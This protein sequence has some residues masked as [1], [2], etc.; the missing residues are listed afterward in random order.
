MELAE[1]QKIDAI[2]YLPKGGNLTGGDQNGRVKTYTVEVSMTGADDSW[3]KVEITPSTQE[4]AN[5]TDWKIAQ[6]VQPVEAK[7]IRFT[8]VETYGD[9]GQE[10]KFM[11]AA[12][13]RVKLAEDEP[14][15]PEPKPTELVIQNQPTKT[16][17]TEGEK[18]DPT[19]LKV[20]VK[21][22]NGEVKDVAEYNA[23]TAGQFT[24]DPALNTALTTNNTKVTVTYKGKTADIIIQVNPKEEEPKVTGIEV[25]TLPKTKYTEGDKFDP[26]GLVLTVKYDK[27]EDKEVAYG[28]A[29]KADFTFSPSLDTALKTSDEKVTVTYA[30]KTAEIG[31]EVKA[32]T[33]VEPEKPTVDKIAVK[34][35]PAKTTYKVGE[36]FD[37]AGL[38]LTVKYN[39]GEDK[40]VAYSDATKA[41]FAFNPSLDT[42]LTE[43]VSKVDVTYAGKT[44]EIGIEVKADTPVEPETPTVDKVE[45]KANPAK[46]EYK[47]GEKFDPKG[48]VLTVTMSD[49]TTKVVA[50]GPET[51]KDFSFNPS[52]NTKLTADTKKVT[53]TYGG[54]SADVAVSVKADPSEDKKP[55]D[56][57]K[58]PNTEK[59][60][61]GGAVQTGDN[62]NVTLLIGLV[63]LAGVTAGG[64]ALTIFKR[65]KRK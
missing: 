16:T 60:D 28:D 13:I 49:G 58:K 61:K 31:I 5:G 62:F 33:P 43:G 6:F 8:G 25:K 30:G 27:G 47:E 54:Q 37:P 44:V 15:V 19:G 41:D 38:V 22:D 39:K 1:A 50:Y 36:K 18:F 26:T 7:F 23:E 10:N 20:G 3:T 14:V 17:Y 35:V 11:S 48:L 57:D 53:V 34:K 64:T 2:R 52:L 55:V 32:D 40:E 63:V 51:A 21:Y 56:P 12:E 65:N 29:T 46:T 42:A 9:G 59:P 24:F 4:W 45:I